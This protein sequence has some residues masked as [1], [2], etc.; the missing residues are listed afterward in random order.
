MLTPPVV[1]EAAEFQFAV[2]MQFPSSM[3]QA[4]A[5]S[6]IDNPDPNEE[7]LGIGAYYNDLASRGG[8]LRLY[9]EDDAVRDAVNQPVFGRPSSLSG[10]WYGNLSSA[11]HHLPDILGSPRSTLSPSLRVGLVHAVQ[12]ERSVHELLRRLSLSR[13]GSTSHSLNP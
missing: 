10:A 5:T 7:F 8:R 9:A 1:P 13:G 2:G 4:S 3:V 12:H 6:A 11:R